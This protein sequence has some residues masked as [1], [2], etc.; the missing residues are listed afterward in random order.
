MAHLK[1]YE[2][3]RQTFPWAQR[4]EIIPKLREPVAR[5]I[6]RQQGI[7]LRGVQ[8]TKLGGGHAW[9]NEIA[10][11]RPDY[12]CS[13]G[14]I[15]HEIA[16]CVDGQKY[17]GNGHR[18]T[19]KR[20]LIK[21]YCETK[22]DAKHLLRNAKLQADERDREAKAN[23]ERLWAQS[24]RRADAAAYRKTREYK[25]DRLRERIKKLDTR[26]KRLATIRKSAE[27]SLR[28][29]ER[30]TKTRAVISQSALESALQEHF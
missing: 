18:A 30:A 12:R 19:F 3:E 6:A 17:G 23:L 24:K 22:Q 21:V 9:F 8:L 27:R 16:H 13:L 2:W 14:I 20:A 25:M 7:F 10:L 28:A 11:P 15:M 4:I 26:M 1:V 5:L 29:Y